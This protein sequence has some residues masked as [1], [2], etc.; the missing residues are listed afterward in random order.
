M[1]HF[2][3]S[4]FSHPLHLPKTNQFLENPPTM[5][6]RLPAVGYEK[7]SQILPILQSNQLFHVACAG[8]IGRSEY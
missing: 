4:P 1:S 5:D 8:R 7:L 3:F 6:Y 2:V